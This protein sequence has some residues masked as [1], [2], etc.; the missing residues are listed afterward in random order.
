MKKFKFP[1]ESLKK[2]RKFQEDMALRDLARV[3]MRVN[4]QEGIKEKAFRLLGAEM[5]T[6]ETKYRTEFQIDLFQMYD[7]YLERLNT[8]ARAAQARLE[9]IRPE[10]EA[11][12]AKVI[13][14]R[15]KLRIVELL[16]ERY[17][18]RYDYELRRHEKK[19]IDEA[20]MR[21]KQKI[22]EAEVRHAPVRRPEPDIEPDEQD[23]EIP[24]GET[25]KKKDAIGEY[26]DRMGL[27]DP[28]EKKR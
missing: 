8:E 14:A 1:L 23:L 10:L 13:E 7:L 4:E 28:R 11:E 26:Y 25:D 3:M 9:E 17:K 6:F 19:I 2:V 18:E 16:K 27:E 22:E 24:S 21:T 15:K 5:D 20:N 12:R